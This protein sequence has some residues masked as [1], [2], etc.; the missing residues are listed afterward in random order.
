MTD[1]QMRQRDEDEGDS[2]QSDREQ[3]ELTALKKDGYPDDWGT[4]ELGLKTLII[5]TF[6]FLASSV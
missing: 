3:A 1:E 4:V 5:M 2:D 6:F